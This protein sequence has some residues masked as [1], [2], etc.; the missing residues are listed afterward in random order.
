MKKH[1]INK[2]SLTKTAFFL[3]VVF[4]LTSLP[5]PALAAQALPQTPVKTLI[6]VGRAVG[7]RL[8]SDGVMVI[9]L[10]AVTTKDGDISPATDAGLLA[11]DMITH[12]DAIPISSV[13][14]LKDAVDASQGRTVSVQF[15]R[16]GMPLRKNLTPVQSAMD[17][18][19]KMGAWVRDSMAG[20]GTVTF[21]DPDSGLFGAL[22][23]GINEV[24]T[25]RLMPM[26]SGSVLESTIREV[27][28]GEV[29]TP[30]ELKGDFPDGQTRG[31]LIA[32]TQAGVFGTLDDPSFLDLGKPLPMA[33][34]QEAQTGPVV[35]YSNVSG[36]TVEPYEAEIVKV[37]QN[38]DDSGRNFMIKITDPKLLERT[39][40][41][42]QGMSGSPVIQNGKFLG[43]VTHVLINDPK[44]GYGI[45]AETMLGEG[46]AN[47][48]KLA[49]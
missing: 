14:G 32:N 41:I 9:G 34:P 43:A 31:R 25:G 21:Y 39:G 15:N 17:G 3:A 6:P 10:S 5:A 33:R 20:I 35:I 4:C 27:R 13:A 1:I 49:S 23:H 24:D 47:L 38:G 22:G 30:G 44:R 37:F 7:L 19:Y 48:Q 2:M 8:A 11:G 46:M 16:D 12:I 36:D 29:G 40:G 18:L 28:R 45:F 26:A 42:V